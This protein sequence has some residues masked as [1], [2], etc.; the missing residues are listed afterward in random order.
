MT[1][2][3]KKTTVVLV[4]G[5]FDILHQGHFDFLKKAKKQGDQ[6][7]VLLES[8][9]S[10]AIKKGKGRPINNQLKRAEALNNLDEVD[11]VIS[12]PF[13]DSSVGYDQVIAQIRP[14]IIA[15]T[16]KDPYIKHK[17]RAAKKFG[18]KIKYVNRKIA[19]LSTSL[20]INENR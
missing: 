20:L 19:G 12:L 2:V 7:I 17:K 9:Q 1:Q 3:K 13:I 6:L 16:F 8:D 10:V 4:G 14:D 11:L 15:T 18:A 5:C